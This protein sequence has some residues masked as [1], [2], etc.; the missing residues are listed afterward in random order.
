[1]TAKHCLIFACLSTPPRETL[2]CLIDFLYL[3][4]PPALL[5]CIPLIFPG[6][7]G[8][9]G[10]TASGMELLFGCGMC[11]GPMLAYEQRIL[12]CPLSASY[13]LR[14]VVPHSSSVPS[15]SFSP[16]ICHRAVNL[17]NLWLLNRT[18]KPEEASLLL[19][20]V[21]GLFFFKYLSN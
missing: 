20:Q 21:H 19:K 4:T 12:W 8:I 9:R 17:F 2:V 1:M 5:C 18:T 6:G 15:H 16:R 3:P 10:T 13:W 11:F 14:P 7:D